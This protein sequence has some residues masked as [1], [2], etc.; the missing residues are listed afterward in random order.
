MV[1]QD[2]IKNLRAA[3]G[4]VSTTI[5]MSAAKGIISAK[6]GGLLAESGGYIE[7]TKVLAKSLM[8]RM[9][10]VKRKASNAGKVTLSNFAELKEEFLADISAEELMNYIPPQLI[11]NWDQTAIQLVPKGQW[12]MNQ[13][14]DKV[15]SIAHSDDKHQI[16]AV[17]AAS[18]SGECISIQLFYQGKM[19]R[20]HP[21]ISF[22]ENWD[23]WHSTD[24][25]SNEETMIRYIK[26]IIAPFVSSKNEALKLDP[27]YS[28]LAIMDGFRGQATDT[29][30]DLLKENNI[31]AIRVPSNCKDKL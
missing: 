4:A 12:T 14:K 17:V 24:H 8:K 21:I 15:I 2:Y 6:D 27:A 26:K 13:A 16:T 28:A 1:V 11:F 5:V 20:C 9:G 29:V 7:I 23:V 10:Y 22:P 25:W 18:K 30:M 31:V 3:G 19:V